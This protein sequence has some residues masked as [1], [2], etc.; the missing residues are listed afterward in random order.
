MGMKDY[1][2][3]LGEMFLKYNPE[4]NN[5]LEFTPSIVGGYDPK[6]NEYIVTFPSIISNPDSGYAAETYVWSDSIATWDE[7]TTKPEN[8]FDD[9]VVIFNPVTVAFSEESNRWTSFYSYIP[10]YYCK[11]NRQFVT[12]K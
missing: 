12:F 9:K 4:Y 10:E 8:A 11:V 7:I 1:F 2:R 5:D 3:D 6:Y